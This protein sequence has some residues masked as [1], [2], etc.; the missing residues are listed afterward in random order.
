MSQRAVFVLLVCFFFFKLYSKHPIK[1]YLVY[2]ATHSET[3]W[4]EIP[5]IRCVNTEG[6]VSP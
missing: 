2:L 3:G 1:M 5:E 4:T 6:L